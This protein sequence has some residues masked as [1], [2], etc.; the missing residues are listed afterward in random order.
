MKMLPIGPD[1]RYDLIIVIRRV[2]VRVLG[3]DPEQHIQNQHAA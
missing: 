3:S 2:A 1:P